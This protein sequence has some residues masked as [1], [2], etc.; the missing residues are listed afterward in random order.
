MAR[1]ENLE[2]DLGEDWNIE[3]DCK[4][5]TG[6]DLDLTG[7][8]VVF[9]IKNRRQQV[10]LSVSTADEGITVD[11]PAAGKA[12]ILIQAADQSVLSA[13]VYLYGATVTLANGT[14]SRQVDG[15]FHARRS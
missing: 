14:I 1:Q 13:G 4:D 3:L 11:S 8:S 15:S 5:A 2:F 10:Q 6:A 12:Y 7:A 9:E